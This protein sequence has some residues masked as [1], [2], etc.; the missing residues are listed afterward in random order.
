MIPAYCFFNDSSSRQAL[1]LLRNPLPPHTHML[2][3]VLDLLG[4][5]VDCARYSQWVLYPPEG[6][7]FPVVA[8]R[9]EYVA[10]ITRA[11]GPQVS[12]SVHC[13]M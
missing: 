3:Q 7:V 4:E 9:D 2:S 8:D 11:A 6:S 1:Q 10:A 12:A 5:S 13:C